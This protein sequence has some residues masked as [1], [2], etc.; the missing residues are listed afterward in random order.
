A[1]IITTHAAAKNPGEPSSVATPISIPRICQ[2]ETTQHAAASPSTTVSAAA[3]G[4][5]T[6]V[7]AGAEVVGAPG[8]QAG[9]SG[10]RAGGRAVGGAGSPVMT[11]PPSGFLRARFRRAV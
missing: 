9:G 10:G 6:A 11:A 8:F 2:T 7:M 5:L 3:A 1:A 4:V